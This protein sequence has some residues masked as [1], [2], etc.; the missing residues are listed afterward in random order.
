MVPAAIKIFRK[1]FEDF[2][3]K[4]ALPPLPAVVPSGLSKAGMGVYAAAFE[5]PGWKPRGRVGRYLPTKPNLAAEINETA[6]I[7]ARTF[8]FRKED[9]QH[10]KFEISFVKPPEFLPDI[11][12]LDRAKA[13]LVKTDTRKSS[14]LLPS[15]DDADPLARLEEA[16]RRG[17]IDRRYDDIR[18]YQMDVETIREE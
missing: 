3:R 5:V 18:I 4:G 12:N 7:L 8:P 13:I 11:A 10:L 2:V 16:L 14:F 9:L 6:A 17:N 1:A 15:L